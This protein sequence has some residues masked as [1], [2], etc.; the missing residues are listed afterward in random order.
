M[1]PRAKR[2]L[3]VQYTAGRLAIFIAAPLILAAIR[4]AG[5]RVRD[6]DKIRKKVARLLDAHS[7]PWLI[8]ANHLTL[9]DSVILLY[10][11]LP[12]SR[13]LARFDQMPWNVPETMNF[14]RNKLLRVMCYI[15]KCIPVTRGGERD[16]V[17]TLLEKCAWLLSAGGNLMI[18]PEGTRSRTGRVNT[19]DFPYGTGRLFLKT[20]GCRVMCIYLRGDGQHTYS[21]FPRC[22]ETFSMF[23]EECFPKTRLKGLRA[24][25]D[26]A[27]QIVR[28]LAGM[29][30]QYFASRG[31]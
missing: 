13:H 4:I 9:I 3:W 31:K 21:N 28:H 30:K 7:G 18:F 19:V 23:V 24:Q 22:R 17:K 12:V 8:C 26:C 11:M 20:P 25:R 15:T 27:G 10:A 29:E 1:E 5:Y 6:I 14:S 2:A 16:G